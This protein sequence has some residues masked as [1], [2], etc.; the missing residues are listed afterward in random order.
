MPGL[1]GDFTE[2]LV[3]AGNGADAVEELFQRVIF[4]RGVDGVT[5]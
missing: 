3:E 4:V 5:A 2:M 1:A